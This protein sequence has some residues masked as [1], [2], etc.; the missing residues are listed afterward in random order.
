MFGRNNVQFSLVEILSGESHK[1]RSGEIRENEGVER[2]E[3][4][5]LCLGK[6][7]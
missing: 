6:L 5:N 2:G 1:M 3:K 4:P 7:R